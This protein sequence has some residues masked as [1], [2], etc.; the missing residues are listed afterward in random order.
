MR[1]SSI[2]LYSLSYN[3]DFNF[4]PSAQHRDVID[5]LYSGGERSFFTDQ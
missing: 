3:E 4:T 1:F 5:S 2:F